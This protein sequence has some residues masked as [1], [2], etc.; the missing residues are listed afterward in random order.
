LFDEVRDRY[1]FA[2]GRASHAE[3]IATIRDVASRIGIVVDPHTAV[4]VKVAREHVQDG[5]PMIVLETAKAAKFAETVN[6]AL[7]RD[8][9]LPAGFEGLLERPQRFESLPADAD[10]VKAFVAARS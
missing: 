10:A 1:G 3:R 4:A 8:P 5:I 2:S 7:G 9:A 6:E